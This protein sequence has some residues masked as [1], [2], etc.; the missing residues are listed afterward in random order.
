MEKLA[1]PIVM[2][3]SANTVRAYRI[4]PVQRGEDETKDTIFC[5]FFVQQDSE[6]LGVHIP[7][8]PLASF[9]LPSLNTANLNTHSH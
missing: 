7:L 4:V 5:K 8:L 6:L 9:T 2:N 1:R 3:S